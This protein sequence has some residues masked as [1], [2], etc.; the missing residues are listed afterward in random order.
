MKHVSV[1][2]L[3][4]LAMAC[5]RQSTPVF[6]VPENYRSW[7]KPLPVVLDYPVAG[8][9]PTFRVVY[10]NDLAY[11]VEKYQE[12]NGP[13]RFIIPD[14]GIIIKEVYTERSAVGNSE[15]V[16]TIMVKNSLDPRSL[17]GWLYYVQKP[18]DKPRLNQS[19]LCAGCHAAANETHQYFDGNKEDLFRDYL[20]IPFQK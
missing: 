3:T 2:L 12:A 6:K 10:A 7:K 16:L 20:F 17:D 4:L 13:V 1:I 14:G 15:P 11:R 5:S 9:G 8:H 18:G 19:R